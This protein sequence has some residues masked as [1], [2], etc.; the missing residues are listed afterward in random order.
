MSP[1][2]RKMLWVSLGEA[3]TAVEKM[4]ESAADRD[5]RNKLVA[6]LATLDRRLAAA[7]DSWGMLEL[8]IGQGK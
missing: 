2:M 1:I 6:R 8:P 7:R 3:V 5:V 4:I